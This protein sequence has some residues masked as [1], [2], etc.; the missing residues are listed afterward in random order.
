MYDP[1]SRRAEDF[2][3][4]EEIEDTLAWAEEHKS[5]RPLIESLLE[6]A[7]TRTHKLPT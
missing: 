4:R 1:K 5:D 7:V 3:N 2:I 6:K